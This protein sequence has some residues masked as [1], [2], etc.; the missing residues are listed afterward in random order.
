MLHQSIYVSLINLWYRN[1]VYAPITVVQ[2]ATNLFLAPIGAASTF[3]FSTGLFSFVPAAVSAEAR[4]AEF[5]AVRFVFSGHGL[6][7]SSSTE[8][9]QL[10]DISFSTGGRS[11]NSFSEFLVFWT[12]SFWLSF[13]MC[14]ISCVFPFCA[15]SSP[16]SGWI[17]FEAAQIK[18]SHFFNPALSSPRPALSPS[19][20]LSDKL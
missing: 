2:G 16:E 3:F 12:S 11:A 1:S 13:L 5:L 9:T 7:I 19:C 6:S 18:S 15:A 4:V 8:V 17:M 10:L 14:F 20:F